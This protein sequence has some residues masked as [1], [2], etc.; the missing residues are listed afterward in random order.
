MDDG[1]E[2]RPDEDRPA[3]DS[4]DHSK[5]NPAEVIVGANGQWRLC[6][7]CARLPAFKRFRVVRPVRKKETRS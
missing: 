3:Y 5:G 7:S 6:A 1:C 2:W 4:D